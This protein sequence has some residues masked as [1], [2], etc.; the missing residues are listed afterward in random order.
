[1][2][3]EEEDVCRY[4]QVEFYRY[5]NGCQISKQNSTLLATLFL[6]LLLHIFSCSYRSSCL[7]SGYLVNDLAVGITTDGNSFC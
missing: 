4:Y 5:I 3:N 7:P 6:D 1:M 2:A